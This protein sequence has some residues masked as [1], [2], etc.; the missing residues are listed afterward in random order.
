MNINYK[1]DE[2]CDLDKLVYLFRT[3]GHNP[4]LDFEEK[5]MMQLIDRLVRNSH[6][7]VQVFSKRKLIGFGRT[8]SDGVLYVT[9]HDIIVHPKFQRKGIGANI[10][11]KL[12]KFY[13]NFPRKDL[14]RVFTVKEAEGF[15]SKLGLEEFP[16]KVFQ[17]PRSRKNHEKLFNS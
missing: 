7:T 16:F 6:H 8:F 13:E 12:L 3:V 14:I 15:Y 2:K 11:K 5:N 17:V 10:V 1:I 9:L 4:Y